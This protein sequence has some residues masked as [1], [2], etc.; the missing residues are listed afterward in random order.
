MMKVLEEGYDS[1]NTADGAHAKKLCGITLYPGNKE[2]NTSSL[3]EK[4]KQ[5]IKNF[6]YHSSPILYPLLH[7]DWSR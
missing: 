5:G 4:F 2:G 6:N 3:L 1:E 7:K